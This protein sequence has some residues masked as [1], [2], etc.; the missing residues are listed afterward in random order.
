MQKVVVASTDVCFRH[1]T[2]RDK[3]NQVKLKPGQMLFGQDLNPRLSEY[4][5]AVF[6]NLQAPCVL[7]IGQAFRYSPENAFYIFNQQIYFII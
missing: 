6:F 4:E 3:E 2:E 7:Y 5:V 1:L